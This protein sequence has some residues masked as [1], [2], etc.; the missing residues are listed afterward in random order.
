MDYSQKRHYSRI[1][2]VGSYW[3]LIGYYA[4]S[5]FI[6]PTDG[7]S[8]F[9]IIGVTTLPLIGFAPGVMREN[10]RALAFMCFVLLIYF[11]LAVVM[12]TP[13]S[14]LSMALIVTLFTSAMTHIRW[15]N[16]AINGPPPKRKKRK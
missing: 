4:I 7:V 1:A 11:T 13:Q 12:W 8:P 10:R 6:Y 15:H 9:L 14:W 3:G 2:S 16:R 5:P